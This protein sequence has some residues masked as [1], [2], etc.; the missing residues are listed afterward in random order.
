MTIGLRELLVITKKELAACRGEIDE[1]ERRG[2]SNDRLHEL[3]WKMVL[4]SQKIIDLE[5]VWN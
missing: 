1:M 3:M 4:L 2:F 5:K